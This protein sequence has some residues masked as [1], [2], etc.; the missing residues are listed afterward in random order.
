MADCCLANLSAIDTVI[1]RQ[2]LLP[3]SELVRARREAAK[4]C[5]LRV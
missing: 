4:E 1:L 3:L 5:I 2:A